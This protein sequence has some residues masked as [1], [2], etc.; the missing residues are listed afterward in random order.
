[1]KIRGKLLVLLLVIALIPLLFTA[2]YSL[3]SVRNMG[4]SL[5]D[6]AGV[7]LQKRA[8]H[9]LELMIQYNA[10]MLRQKQELVEAWLR[11][12]AD[13]AEHALAK[14][15][16][17]ARPAYLAVDYDL[18]RIPRNQIFP[19][20]R[21]FRHD[22]SGRS[23]PVPIS[24]HAQVLRLA[25]GV[26]PDDVA[27]SLLRLSTLT[28]V[29]QK[30][31]FHHEDLFYWVITSLD[32]GVHSSYPGH[33]S[34]P[35]DYDA[36]KRSWYMRAVQAGELVWSDFIIDATTGQT[37]ATVS[38]PIYYKTGMLAGVVAIDV[39]VQAI[40]NQV[41]TE[42]ELS[43][44][45]RVYLVNAIRDD[46]GPALELLG[47]LEDEH[48][49]WH[50]PP[51]KTQLTSADPD[52]DTMIDDINAG[53]PGVRRMPLNGEDSVWAYGIYESGA[54]ALVI[55]IPFTHVVEHVQNAKDYILGETLGIVSIIAVFVLVLI[56]FIV[57]AAWGS[58]LSVTKP[59]RELAGAAHRLAGGDFAVRVP[60]RSKDEIGQLSGVFNDIAPQLLDRIKAH[61]S[62][63]HLG[64]Y[65]SPNLAQQLTENPELLDVGGERRDM[66]FVFTDLA[67]FTGLV[68]SSRPEDIVPILNEYLDGMTRIVWEHEGTIDKVVGD[69]VHAMFGAP[70][71]QPD[72]AARGVSCALDMDAYSESF[73][74]KMRL[75]GVAIG[76]TRIGINTGHAT[77]G[78]FG[79]ELMFDYTAHGDAI[80]TAARLEGAN[81]FFGTRIAVSENTTSEIAP[82]RGRPIG[83]LILKGRST[84]LMT[85]EPV[86]EEEHASKRIQDYLE[87]YACMAGDDAGALSA[88]KALSRSYPDDPL[89]QFH[90]TRLESGECGEIIT[91]AGK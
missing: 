86:T 30:G 29:Y 51:T 21:H 79:G 89:V 84:G 5:A 32:N 6:Q 4:E 37:I 40:L 80:N 36:R 88:F 35:P 70:L 2:M 33:G 26:D 7:A 55:V 31:Y 38:K 76:I 27:E 68:E 72:H 73:R 90:L 34:Y 42:A 47:S 12:L 14:T 46:K 20:R 1:M 11:V 60:V 71:D 64:R 52:F 63:T 91:L 75:E 54:H 16:P 62:L 3:V 74:E 23:T 81:K 17:V 9:Q 8:A 10:R 39:P 41:R 43:R 69:A 49:D 59:V 13:D 56:G 24:T 28:S 58:S 83:K 67:G 50:E 15:N 78:N 53:R 45:A 82:F 87:A 61:E 44:D 66:T 22:E 19:S 48:R 18:D 85:Y 57:A 25:P 77:V 65:F